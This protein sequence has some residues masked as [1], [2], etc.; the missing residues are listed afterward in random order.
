MIPAEGRDDECTSRPSTPTRCRGHPITFLDPA[1]RDHAT[2]RN[3]KGADRSC[4]RG[5][6]PH[7]VCGS[8]DPRSGPMRPRPARVGRQV[9]SSAPAPRPIE[10]DSRRTH[11]RREPSTPP[12]ASFDYPLLGAVGDEGE[13]LFDPASR[14]AS[15]RN[16]QDDIVNTSDD[17]RCRRRNDRHHWISPDLS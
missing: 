15:S 12:A 2:Q 11:R 3:R 13:A 8:T 1:T 6:V 7:R 14:T 4:P 10:A 16:N 9:R 5:D 17:F